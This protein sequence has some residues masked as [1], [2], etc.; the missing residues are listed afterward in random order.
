MRRSMTLLTLAVV[1][2]PG[3]ACDT[4]PASALQQCEATA[5]LPDGVA[6]D[7]LFVIDDSG[8]MSQEQANLA[9]NLG[10]FIDALAAS[11]VQNDFQIGVTTTSVEGFAATDRSYTS[12]PAAGVPYPAGALVAIRRS[13]AGAGIPGA[14]TYDATAYASTGGWG[15]TRLL[16]KGS[17]TLVE[18]FKANVL[19]GTHGSGKEQPFR[20]A[21]LALTDRLLDANAGFLRDGARLAVIFVTDEDD[22]SESAGQQAD[23]NARCHDPA[24]KDAS[25]PILDTVAGFAAFLLGPVGG[26]LRDVTVGAIAGFDP[27]GLAPSCGDP[28][29]CADLACSTAMDQGTRIHQLLG[30]LG[31]ARMRLGSICDG[32]FRDT[33]ALFAQDLMPSA[34]P[35]A[36][37]PADW[38]MLVVSLTRAAG[39]VVPCV[40]A[41]EGTAGQAAADA[42]Y[43]AP[44]L[45]QPAEIKFQNACQLGLGDRIDVRVVC[46]G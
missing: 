7:I 31:G 16:T 21:R 9:T 26:Q 2:L 40:L 10:A 34:L 28:T 23:S 32:S 18:D 4:V 8:S 11:A 46:A 25:P 22:C 43:V 12:G 33:L 5:V 1:L 20:V 17:A 3:C 45:G 44:R 15:G 41:A 27:S 42:V 6:T 38:R 24:V 39:G 37:A 13:V 19:V 30:A 29:L 14:L 35:L 36:G